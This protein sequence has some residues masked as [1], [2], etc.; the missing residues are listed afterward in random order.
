VPILRAK[1]RSKRFWATI[2]NRSH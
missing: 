2:S 1:Y